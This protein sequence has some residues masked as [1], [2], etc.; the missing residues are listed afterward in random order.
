MAQMND[1]DSPTPLPKGQRTGE[2]AASQAVPFYYQAPMQ[3][4]G[5]NVGYPAF[6]KPSVNIPSESSASSGYYPTVRM[7]SGYGAYISPHGN[8]HMVL[9][10]QSSNSSSS[11][12]AVATGIGGIKLKEYQQVGYCLVPEP[13]RFVI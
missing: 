1:L 3:V 9:A 4:P 8:H 7:P 12:G 13:L 2:R 11:V 5:M 10:S 6:T